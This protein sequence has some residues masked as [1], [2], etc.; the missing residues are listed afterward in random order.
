[1]RVWCLKLFHNNNYASERQQ[2]SGSDCG[3]STGGGFGDSCGDGT[4]D[5]QGVDEWESLRPVRPVYGGA[6]ARFH[7]QWEDA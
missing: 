1:V 6:R 5:G 3:R 2:G 4:G 7:L